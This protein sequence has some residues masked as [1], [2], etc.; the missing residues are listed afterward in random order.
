[1]DLDKINLELSIL[2]KS[3]NDSFVSINLA[4]SKNKTQINK[5]EQQFKL[6]EQEIDKTNIIIEEIAKLPK[7]VIPE[8][9]EIVISEIIDNDLNVQGEVFEFDKLEDTEIVNDKTPMQLNEINK[10]PDLYKQYPS[11]KFEPPSVLYN[12]QH[13]PGK[14]FFK[15]KYKG[16]GRPSIWSE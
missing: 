13:T 1:M 5:I 16:K 14:D 10:L 7:I 9:P 12:K 11:P 4:L 2:F 8:L 15:F 6:L 3:L